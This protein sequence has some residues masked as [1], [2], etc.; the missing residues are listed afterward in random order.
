MTA[1]GWTGELTALESRADVDSLEDLH[2]RRRKLIKDN[3]RILALHGPFGLFDDYRKQAL[4]AQKI[5]ARKNLTDAGAKIT[6]ALVDAEAY[7][8]AAYQKILDNAIEDKVTCLTVLIGIA[9]LEERI[10]SR[11]FALTAYSAETRLGR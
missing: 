7:G 9:E 5:V 8:S 10:R 1:T 6:E 4:E 11:E 3:E 2:Q